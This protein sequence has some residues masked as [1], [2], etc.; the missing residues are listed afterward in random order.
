M[1]RDAAGSAMNLLVFTENY[2][3]GGSN[4]YIADM[5]N[6]IKDGYDTI[7][8]A[9]NPQGFYA[10]DISRL[11]KPVTVQSL[12]ILTRA[13][14]NYV[15]R[16]LP[17]L[18]RAVPIVL[19]KPLEPFLF[20]YNVFLGFSLIRRTRPAMVLSCSGGYPAGHGALAMVVAARLAKVP[21]ALSIVS[22][23]RKRLCPL[24]DHVLDALVWHS[25]D[26][27]IVNARAI[28]EALHRMRGLPLSKARIVYNGLEQKKAAGKPG[29][30]EL[31]IGCVARMDR[32]KGVLHLF[33]AFADLAPRY[34]S[35]RLMLVGEGPA[36]AELAQ[37][38]RQL[39]LQ[40]RVR[41]TGYFEGD[42]DEL[43]ASFDLYVFPSLH[44]GFPYSILEAMRA[45]CPIIATA[46]GGIPEAI[47]DGKDGL[48]VRPGDSEAL[49]TAIERLIKDPGTRLSLGVNARQRFQR[50]FSLASMHHCLRTI[51]PLAGR[52]KDNK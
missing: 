16:S 12:G 45:G 13:R 44:E 37:R 18:V 50:E 40:D 21:S 38:T 35:L 30:N 36:L 6:G 52:Q 25:A 8:I 20:L 5:V 48:L 14:L 2:A 26:L 10:E 17:F 28:A 29:G 32:A 22:M 49:K 33:K 34:P 39:G 15:L 41:L 51:Q 1:N 24:Y 11:Q 31:V 42:P 47:L 23:P 43:L 9:S 7:V 19:A 3:R 27:V 46:V 4:R